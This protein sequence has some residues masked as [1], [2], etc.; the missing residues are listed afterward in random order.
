MKRYSI[1]ARQVGAPYETEVC[2]C[3]N[4]PDVIVAAL[5]KKTTSGRRHLPIYEMIRVV[6]HQ[7][8]A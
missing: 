3:E 2:Q 5:Q 8:S 6:D 4:N 1:V 7:E